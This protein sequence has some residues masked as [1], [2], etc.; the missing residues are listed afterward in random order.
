MPK[1]NLTTE[2]HFEEFKAVCLHW[3]S[4]L[5]LTDWRI[6]ID[7][8]DS[9]Y[10]D[11]FAGC[12]ISSPGRVSTITLC[13]DWQHEK[14]TMEQVRRSAR[15]EVLENLLL[16]LQMLAEDRFVTY[17]QITEAKHSIV[18]RLENLMTEIG[19]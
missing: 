14:V 4:R 15:H 10:G 7:H 9:D 11:E 19:E 8:D 2:K 5:G 1:R 18:R 17:E 16:P 12:C 13:K 3:I 6:H